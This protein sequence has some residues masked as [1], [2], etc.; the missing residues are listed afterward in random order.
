MDCTL[1]TSSH[2][3]HGARIHFRDRGNCSGKIDRDRGIEEGE[4][5]D[6]W[7]GP[8]ETFSIQR[9]REVVGPV[10]TGILFSPPENLE[11]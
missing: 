1:V 2:G 7:Q 4:D 10:L 5:R 9:P 8:R 6:T 11:A 3:I